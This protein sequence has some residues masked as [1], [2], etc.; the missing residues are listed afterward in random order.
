MR[1]Q[2]G[3]WLWPVPKACNRNRATETRKPISLNACSNHS[4]Q[5]VKN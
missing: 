1:W 5:H 4:K 2:R 3:S